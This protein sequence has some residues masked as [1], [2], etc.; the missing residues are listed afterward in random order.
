MSRCKSL[1]APSENAEKRMLVQKYKIYHNSW[2]FIFISSKKLKYL[3]RRN[4]HL[5]QKI[6]R[7][8]AHRCEAPFLPVTRWQLKKDT[9]IFA[10]ISFKIAE[11]GFEPVFAHLE[12]WSSALPLCAQSAELRVMR[13]IPLPHISFFLFISH[14]R[15]D[16]NIDFPPFSK[17]AV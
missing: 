11:T 9:S 4:S 3:N 17:N 2:I 5:H 15:I 8:C 10:C 6:W 16:T 13:Q 12:I 14:F 7:A 1:I